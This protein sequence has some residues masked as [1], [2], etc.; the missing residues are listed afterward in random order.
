MST[1]WLWLLMAITAGAAMPL[2]AGINSTLAQQ[3]DGAIWA[4]MVSFLV[5]T[6]ALCVLTLIL[7]QRLWP[8]MAVITDTP[9][10][11]WIGGFLG[12]VFVSVSVFLAPRIGGAAL[13]VALLAGQLSAS[14]FLDKIGWATF[15]QHDI[16]LGRIAG[17]VLVILGVILIKRF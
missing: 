8:G 10:W 6:V 11:A 7:N 16:S 2:Q 4:A 12:A 13:M 1:E 14:I 5:G 3:G 9:S 17:I 15:P